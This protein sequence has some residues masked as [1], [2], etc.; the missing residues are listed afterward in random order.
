MGWYNRGKTV[1]NYRDLSLFVVDKG[2]N[3]YFLFDFP[4]S[5]VISKVFLFFMAYNYRF[6]IARVCRG[7]EKKRE[8]QYL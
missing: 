8:L 2:M 6:G 4:F 3:N 5:F 7:F 1:V